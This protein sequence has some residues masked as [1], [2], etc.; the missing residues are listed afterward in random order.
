MESNILVQSTSVLQKLMSQ[1]DD[2]FLKNSIVAQISA[3]IFYNSE[4]MNQVMQNPGF[5]NKFNYMVYNQIEKDFGNYVDAK[6]RISKRSLHHIYE[7]DRAGEAEARLFKLSRKDGE[8][9]SF[10]INYGFLPSKSFAKTDLKRRHVFVNKASVME[11]GMPLKI[12]PRFSE[13]LVFESNGYTVFMPKGASVTVRR[14]GGPGVKNAFQM[15]YTHFFSGNLVN[16]S[17][18]RSGFQNLFNSSIA[19]A[20]NLPG[21]IK[22]VKYKFSPN[23]IR[24]Q[25]KS[26][27]TTAFGV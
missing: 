12:A 5:K 3:Y 21:D 27:V 4:V 25:A 15:A 18:K 7:W 26:A 10:K 19:I 6:A 1:A 17:I 23:A 8:G 20:L 16:E 24:M 11:A 13:R 22:R 9:I 2:G 14:P